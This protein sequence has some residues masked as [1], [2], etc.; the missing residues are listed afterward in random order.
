MEGAADGKAGK[1]EILE[2]T[3]RSRI[4]PHTV[5]VSELCVMGVCACSASRAK[6]IHE[7]H[8]DVPNL[9]AL[10]YARGTVSSRV[11]C[12]GKHDTRVKLNS[13]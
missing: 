9:S 7:I 5:T 12:R 13:L 2:V 6:A 11:S 3:P 4:L 8:R 1:G 10:R